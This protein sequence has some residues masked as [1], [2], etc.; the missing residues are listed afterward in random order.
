MVAF[1]YNEEWTPSY[2]LEHY[3]EIVFFIF[4]FDFLEITYLKT[5]D[6]VFTVL[7]YPVLVKTIELNNNYAT[8]MCTLFKY[9]SNDNEDTLHS[10][11]FGLSKELHFFHEA[12]KF[13]KKN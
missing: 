4:L 6:L 1:G 8:L 13:S 9:K 11:T 3:I 7:S 12:M 5:L 10:K 2:L